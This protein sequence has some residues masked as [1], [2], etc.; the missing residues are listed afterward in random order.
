MLESVGKGVATLG[1]IGLLLWLLDSL[2]PREE[3][4][5]WL[6]GLY[7][8][9]TASGAATTTLAPALVVLVLLAWLV[10]AVYEGRDMEPG[11]SFLVRPDRD[12]ADS[13]FASG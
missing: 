5:P 4:W 6:A 9:L 7:E 1:G 11:A 12:D 8:L 13:W 3:M 10:A 2:I